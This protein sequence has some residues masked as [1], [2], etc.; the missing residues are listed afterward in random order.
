MKI[1]FF[2]SILKYICKCYIISLHLYEITTTNRISGG[3]D[4]KRRKVNCYLSCGNDYARICGS[5][6]VSITISEGILQMDEFTDNKYLTT[7]SLPKTIKSLP[8]SPFEGCPNLTLI[9]YAGTLSDWNALLAA[10]EIDVN[11]VW[12]SYWDYYNNE[13]KSIHF[14]VR[15]SDGRIVYPAYN[16]SV[17]LRN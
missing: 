4:E 5:D 14:T 8:Y 12:C 7:L 13:E 16:C 1:R 6:L 17:R 9:N 11:E 3:K 10:D 15:C 2:Q